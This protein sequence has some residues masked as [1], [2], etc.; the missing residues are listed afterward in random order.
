MR[1]LQRLLALTLVLS[2]AALG[3]VGCGQKN[4]TGTQAA[5]GNGHEGEHPS[6]GPHHG[7]LAEWS[8]GGKEEYHAEVVIDRKDKK[9]TVYVLDETAKK[10]VAID[11]KEVNL[12]IKSPEVKQFTLKAE[13]EG[14]ASQFSVTDDSFGKSEKM[15]GKVA[16]TIGGKRYDAPFDEAKVD[17]D[18]DH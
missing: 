11:A 17:K 8:V 15:S 14:K 16:T 1:S 4:K 2:L 3:G 10:A 7:P 6:E 18:H 9:A 5:G 12:N 13:G